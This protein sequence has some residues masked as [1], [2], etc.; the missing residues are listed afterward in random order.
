MGAGV[1]GVELPLRVDDEPELELERDELDEL[2]LRDEL[3]DDDDER[4]DDE[5]ELLLN[6][7]PPPGR[8]REG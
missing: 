8:P 5:E 7:L 3:D 1:L 6:E 2:E 4:D